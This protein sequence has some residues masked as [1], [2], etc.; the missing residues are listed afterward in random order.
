M[1]LQTTCRM[2]YIK[3]EIEGVLIIQPRVFEEADAWDQL[4]G[5]SYLYLTDQRI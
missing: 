4:K 2:E 3:T 1:R 5:W